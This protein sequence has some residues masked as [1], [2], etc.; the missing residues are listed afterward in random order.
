M[1]IEEIMKCLEALAKS[2][3]F[4]SRFCQYL[5][6]LR[7]DFPERWEDVVTE[8]ESQNFKDSV[9]LVMYLEG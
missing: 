3:G 9:D 8:L 5:R 4:Y 7:E 6:Q 2:Q 1:N